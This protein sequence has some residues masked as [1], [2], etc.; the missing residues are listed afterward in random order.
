MSS[1]F[2]YLLHNPASYHK[3][4]EEIRMNFKSGNDIQAGVQLTGCKY[5]RACIDES[6]RLAPPSIAILWREQAY[7]DDK[8]DPIIVDG[9][10]IPRGTEVGVSLYSLLHNEEYF[11]E[12]FTFKPERWLEPSQPES[13]EASQARVLMHRAFAPFALGA[14][15]CAGKAMAYLE[16]SLGIAKTVWYFDFEAAPG[17]LGQI[18]GGTAGSTNGRHRAD[19]YQLYDNVTASHDGP[20]VVLHPRGNACEE[21]R[22][23]A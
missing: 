19:E 3:L 17:K 2:F 6:L 10:V 23:N 14:R 8:N 7:D 5:L 11:P 9:R 20:F 13:Q 22:Q 1:V 12:P 18:G 4:T 16:D 15:G 21:L